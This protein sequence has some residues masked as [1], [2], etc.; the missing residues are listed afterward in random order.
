MT[1]DEAAK[2]WPLLCLLQTSIVAWCGEDEN[3]MEWVAECFDFTEV[4]KLDAAEAELA[5]LTGKQLVVICQ[6]EPGD[7]HPNAP[8]ACEVLDW[9]NN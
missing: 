5:V 8:K 6:M 4:V 1:Y 9:F 3:P 7:R 2:R